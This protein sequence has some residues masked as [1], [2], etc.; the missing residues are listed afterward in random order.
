MVFRKFDA[1]KRRWLPYPK[2]YRS[3][4]PYAVAATKKVVEDIGSGRKEVVGAIMTAFP[5]LR[6]Q[7]QLGLH[8]LPLAGG[9]IH[10][11][12]RIDR[13]DSCCQSYMGPRMA[14][15]FPVSNDDIDFPQDFALFYS[16]FSYEGVKFDIEVARLQDPTNLLFQ[17]GEAWDSRG[18]TVANYTY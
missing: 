13:Q 1:T 9:K 11:G 3:L 6:Q 17:H 14:V 16:P 18:E 2:S 5:I 7:H 8:D 4:P 12:A 15:I 10:Q